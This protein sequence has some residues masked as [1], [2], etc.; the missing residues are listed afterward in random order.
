MA[1]SDAMQRRAT[2]LLDEFNRSKPGENSQAFWEDRLPTEEHEQSELA[3]AFDRHGVALFNRGHT[4]AA[5]NAFLPNFLLR[6]KIVTRHPA[7]RGA[8]RDFASAEDLMG[9]A[10]IELNKLSKAEEMLTEALTYR[11]GLFQDDPS[12]AHA[13]TLY[14]VALS[15]MGRLEQAKGNNAPA[16]T[17]LT[18]ARDHLVEVNKMWPAVSFIEM[19]LAEVMTR[20]STM[21]ADTIAPFDIEA[22]VKR[23][24]IWRYLLLRW[25]GAFIDMVLLVLFLLTPD[26]VLGNPL[27]QETLWIWVTP[28]ILY[29][30]VLEG[31][32]GRTLGKL[33]AGTMVV[34]NSGKA[35]GIWKAVLRTIMRLIEVNPVGAGGVLA[36]IVVAMSQKRQR[37][38]DMLARTY[39]VRVKDLA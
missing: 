21:T 31:I 17:Y 35:P 5:L 29:F 37:L 16:L 19:E 10:F 34:D 6:L 15:H 26:F 11:R 4:Q 30:P 2:L 38:G 20:L 24:T 33:I 9:L 1:V 32:W 28:V 23:S 27:Y 7:D 3:E 13:A 22:I 12:D 25:L 14:G 18:Q 36:G 8:I 39:V